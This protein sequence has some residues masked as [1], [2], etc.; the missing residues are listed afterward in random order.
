MDIVAIKAPVLDSFVFPF[1]S[2]CVSKCVCSVQCSEFNVHQAHLS[3]AIQLFSS[4]CWFVL[5]IVFSM[6]QSCFKY[7]SDSC[8]LCHPSPQLSLQLLWLSYHIRFIM[9]KTLNAKNQTEQPNSS[10]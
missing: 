6:F 7:V 3:Y 2:P 10:I 5:I 4:C 9:S 8:D 1:I